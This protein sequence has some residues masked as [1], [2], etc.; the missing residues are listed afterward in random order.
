MLKTL[1]FLKICKPNTLFAINP[2]FIDDQGFIRFA[3]IHCISANTYAE[4]I[5]QINSGKIV[6]VSSTVFEIGRAHV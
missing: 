5:R 4:R 3:G 6:D 1:K 2:S